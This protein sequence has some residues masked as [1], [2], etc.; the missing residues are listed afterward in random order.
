VYPSD[1]SKKG[2]ASTTGNDLLVTLVTTIGMPAVWMGYYGHS[3][4]GLINPNW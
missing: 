3:V 4:N 2:G 1:D